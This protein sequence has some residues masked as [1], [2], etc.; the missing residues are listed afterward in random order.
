[1]R[2]SGVIRYAGKRGVVWRIKYVDATGK[3][4]QET[5]G[6]ESEGWTRKKAAAELRARVVRTEKKDWKKPSPLTFGEFADTWFEQGKALG[7]WKPRTVANYEGIVRRLKEDL[8]PLPVASIKT[9]RLDDYVTW[10]SENQGPASLNRDI[11]ILH[12]I[13]KSAKRKGLVEVNPVEDV[14]RPKITQRDWRILEPVEVGAVLKAFTD[15]QARTVFLTLILTGVRRH[16]LKNLV[17]RDVGLSN[18]DGPVMRIRD[19][20]SEKG[21]RS[22]AIPPV[23]SEALWQHR[24]SSTYQGEDEFVFTTS[25]GGKLSDKVFAAQFREALKKAGIE[26]YVRPFHDLRHSAITNDAASGYNAVE[27]MTKAGHSDMKTTK[28]YMHLAGVVFRERAEISAERLLG[29]AVSPV[30][31]TEGAE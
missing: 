9:S 25:R 29:A 8:G 22:I 17:W 26:D 16:E 30:D 18:P 3:Q 10:A 24:R 20:K 31:A 28:L 7:K 14:E 5:L 13:F 21:I 12:G 11:S 2:N 23:L 4:V 15:E 1:M 27:L 6:K 19:S